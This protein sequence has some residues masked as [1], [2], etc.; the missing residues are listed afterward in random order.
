VFAIVAGMIWLFY[1]QYLNSWLEIPR[2]LIQGFQGHNAVRCKFELILRFGHE[3]T[4]IITLG[5]SVALSMLLLQFWEWMRVGCEEMFYCT[6]AGLDV[7]FFWIRKEHRGEVGEG[8][9]P[10]GESDLR[11]LEEPGQPDA[12]TLLSPVEADA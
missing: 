8:L 9:A 5:L 2:D 7:Y 1:L 3:F 4:R 11:V 6:F 10:R 12:L